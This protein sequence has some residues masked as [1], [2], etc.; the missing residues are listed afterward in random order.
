MKSIARKV[1][2]KLSPR[3]YRPFAVRERIGQVAY[4]LDLPASAKIHPVFHVSQ[5][6]Q[7][8]GQQ[9]KGQP[10]PKQLTTEMELVV[11]PAAVL[12][13]R[14]ILVRGRHVDEVLIHWEGLP[15]WDATWEP[16]AVIRDQFPA[17]NLGDK[18]GLEEGSIDRSPPIRIL[19]LGIG[20]GEGANSVRGVR[21]SACHSL[22]R[23]VVLS[24]HFA[25]EALDLLMDMLNDDSLIV[26]L[27]ALETLYH[28]TA[29][30]HLKLQDKHMHMFL[31]PLADKSNSI[32]YAARKVLKLV[33]LSVL[34]LFILT[35]DALLENL[36]RYPE[37]EVDA[38]SVFFHIGQNHG[39]FVSCIIEEI[40]RQIE[41]T[42]EGKLDFDNVRVG[43]LIVLAISTQSSGELSCDIS[44]TI[45]SYAV[46]MLGRI[47]D[48]LSDV[49]SQSAL[50]A[51]LSKCSQS[52]RLSALDFTESEHLFALTKVGNFRDYSNNNVTDTLAMFLP[53]KIFGASEIQFSGITHPRQYPTLHL[54]YKLEAHDEVIKSL[55]AILARVK[56]IWPLVLTGNLYEVLRILRNCKEE[57]ATFNAN[58]STGVLAFTLQ[59]LR[60]IKL[61][62]KVWQHFLPSRFLA[63][64][65][66]TLD[67]LL[68]KLD[69]WLRELRSRFIGLSKEEELHVLELMLV[70]CTLRLSKIEICC[71]HSTL[72]RLS[73]TM[74]QVE[75]LLK[76]ES[77]QPSEF[78]IE[79]GKLSSK[80]HTSVSG[81]SCGPHLFEGLSEFFCL[82]QFVFCGRLEHVEAELD[83]P[84]N[85]SEHLLCFVPGLPVGISCQ[86]TLHNILIESRLW[87]KMTMDDGLTQF[88]FLDLSLSED[89]DS[90]RR[91]TSN[92]SVC[93]SATAILCLRL[94]LGS[95]WKMALVL[96]CFF[97]EDQGSWMELDQILAPILSFQVQGR[98]SSV[99]LSGVESLCLNPGIDEILPLQLQVLS[100]VRIFNFQHSS[101]ETEEEC[102]A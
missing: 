7:F 15:S 13:S 44:P 66:G 39:K 40:T 38:F 61:L 14:T 3:F 91:E 49:M 96:I 27:Q 70:T 41:P 22:S 80:I 94:S 55:N 93:L 42:C 62:S 54:D 37:D 89:H 71:K 32:R 28:M 73:S 30:D 33:K 83:V 65:M 99:Q 78:E 16:V 95:F 1:N 98:N 97:S 90:Y 63:Y 4:C 20:D 29:C 72:K 101:H 19:D 25:L 81:G 9:Y 34:E 12:D 56:D 51:F 100:V 52:A 23:L 87:L 48:A 46:T 45:F 75:I 102:K 18:V 17:F 76:E 24:A 58:N 85:D 6:K 53:R 26:R 50:L 2:E 82:K 57:L 79:V 35:V 88:I 68:A 36:A 47:A 74:L 86:I 43:A 31:G 21:K 59:Y 60:V 84:H 67:I 69:R 11:N 92:Y 64:R 77:V 5:L 10:L 8:G